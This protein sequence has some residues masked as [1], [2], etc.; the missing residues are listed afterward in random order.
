M[1]ILLCEFIHIMNK[2]V[3]YLLILPTLLNCLKEVL[4]SV[5]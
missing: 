1:F 3:N 2:F 5:R 4:L